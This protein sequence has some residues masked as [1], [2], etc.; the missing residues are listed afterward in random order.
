MT[1][2]QHFPIPFREM[3]RFKQRTRAGFTLIE[4]LIVVTII[5]ILMTI[6]GTA[7]FALLTDA[8]VKRTR[9]IFRAWVTQL[10]QYRETYKHFPPV[11]LQHSEEGEPVVIG[12]DYVDNH[13]KF[14][15]ALKGMKW[16]RDGKE[17]SALDGVF[18]DQNKRI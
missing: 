7:G 17:W 18:R 13:D 5:G 12:E 10:Y 16:N 9:T 8:E 2:F 15:A 1:G 3:K 11:L 14:I 6:V 4:L